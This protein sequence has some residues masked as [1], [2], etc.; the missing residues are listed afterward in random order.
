M[1][2]G[3]RRQLLQP[4]EAWPF[5]GRLVS[6]ATVRGP[7]SR[8]PHHPPS[9]SGGL[10]EEKPPVEA[11]ADTVTLPENLLGVLRGMYYSMIKFFVLDVLLGQVVAVS[12]DPAPD[13]AFAPSFFERPPG[14]LP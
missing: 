7:V 13:R 3:E 8:H 11:M 2:S 14:Q 9:A 1:T 10:G 4:H 6:H 5:V 12:T